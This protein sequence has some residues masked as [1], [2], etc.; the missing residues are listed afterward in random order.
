M[1]SDIKT[2]VR[3]FWEDV[4]PNGDVE[5][6]TEFVH[7]DGINHEARPGSPPGI[8]GVLQA[9]HWLRAAFSDQRFEIHQIIAEGD[10]VAVYLTHH[11]RH[12]GEFLGI[13]PTNRTFAYPHVHIMRFEDGRCIEQWAV[14]DDATFMRQIQGL[15]DQA[16]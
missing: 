9:M 4:W 5:G 1:T 7:P 13:P 14:R 16:A 6:V 3:R 12:T 11:G 8:E 2:T 10:T 15:D